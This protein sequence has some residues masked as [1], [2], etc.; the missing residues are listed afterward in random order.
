MAWPWTA[1]ALFL[2]WSCTCQYPLFR[3]NEKPLGTCKSF[4]GIIDS[5][6]WIRGFLCN[7]IQFQV[8]HTIS[9]GH[10]S[11][12]PVTPGKPMDSRMA[13][14]TQLYASLPRLV[15]PLFSLPMASAEVAWEVLHLQ[16]WWLI[17]PIICSRSWKL[18]GY[19]LFVVYNFSAS[20]VGH[21]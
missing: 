21:S 17:A 13:Q 16:Y 11:S 19:Q 10:L 7:M 3:S 20:I 15:G 6:K 1:I 9:W 4:Q 5:R 18:Q 12:E 14:S 8:F 2:L